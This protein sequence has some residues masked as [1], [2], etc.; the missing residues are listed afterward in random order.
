[1]PP[2]RYGY[3]HALR[4][5]AP[6]VNVTPRNLQGTE[7]L[8]NQPAQVDTG[9]DR[10]VL[11]MALVDELKLLPV[12]EITVGGLG[13]SQH[14]VRTY[15]VYLGVHDLPAALVEVMGYPGEPWIL[16][17]R[18]V[19]NSLRLLLDGPRLVLEIG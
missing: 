15:A 5:P 16:L 11:P 3:Q 2:I 9:A 13:K 17:G 6:F 8:L 12:D 4:I 19:L 14:S 10:T 7:E 1:M 18:D